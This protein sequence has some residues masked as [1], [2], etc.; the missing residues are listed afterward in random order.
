MQIYE[1]KC[2]SLTALEHFVFPRICFLGNENFVPFRYEIFNGFRLKVILI[3]LKMMFFNLDNCH[4][5]Q[6]NAFYLVTTFRSAGNV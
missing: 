4:H 1:R 5:H 3:T 6:K 2:M